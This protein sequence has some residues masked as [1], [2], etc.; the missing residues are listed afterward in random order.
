LGVKAQEFFIALGH[1]LPLGQDALLGFLQLLGEL[2]STVV[3]GGDK[4]VGGG[5]NHGA[6]VIVFEE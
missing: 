2:G 1:K 6:E 3:D 4:A 5:T